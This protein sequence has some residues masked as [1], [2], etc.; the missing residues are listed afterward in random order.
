[1]LVQEIRVERYIELNEGTWF[2]ERTRSPRD[3]GV[4]DRL[5][6]AEAVP[7]VH[8]LVAGAVADGDV[9]ADV[10]EGGVAHHAGQLLANAAVVHGRHL[11]VSG[12]LFSEF[13][14]DGHA[15]DRAGSHGLG[16]D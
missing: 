15:G 4:P 16:F 10:A 14:G 12:A 3:R 13:G 5:R 11:D 7:A 9:A 2:G 6:T 8:T 1:M